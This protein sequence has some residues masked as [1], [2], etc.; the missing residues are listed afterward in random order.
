MTNSADFFAE[1]PFLTEISNHNFFSAHFVHVKSA[2]KAI[3][4]EIPSKTDLG[5]HRAFGGAQI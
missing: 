4:Y 1:N 5:E 2:K 3:F